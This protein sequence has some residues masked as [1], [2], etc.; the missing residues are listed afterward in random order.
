MVRF[1]RHL[2]IG[3]GIPGLY[4]ALQL[5]RKGENDF[6]LLE[7]RGVD[8]GKQVTQ[9]APDGTDIELGSSIEHTNQPKFFDLLNL[10][11]LEKAVWFTP[12]LTNYYVYGN[13]SSDQVKQIYKDCKK[14][15]KAASEKIENQFATL[16][17]LSQKVLSESEFKLFSTCYCCWYEINLENAKHF[18]ITEAN[19]GKYFRLKG[20]QQ[21]LIT[22]S[23]EKVGSH[24]KFYTEVV[25]VK[26]DGKH[27]FTTTADGET[28]ASEYL[29]LT[30]NLTGAKKIKFD[31]ID[32]I[33]KY[34]DLAWS[35][36]CMRWYMVLK[37]G[38]GINIPG[39][40]VG[41]IPGKWTIK[42]SDRVWLISYVDGPLVEEYSKN[43][44][45]SREWIFTMNSLFGTRIK[46]ED[47]EDEIVAV[48]KDA[49]TILK[50]E[51]YKYHKIIEDELPSKLVIT[52]V[53]TPEGQGWIE[54]NLRKI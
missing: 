49:Y 26:Y 24:I 52:T 38:K 18:F 46:A 27:Y 7:K 36:E 29:Y 16:E 53:T 8:R 50:P 39:Y 43:K 37:K 51:W 17:E 1:I 19:E 28:I 30:T 4:I 35:R 6:L 2:I 41:Q 44:N 22:L 32:A 42:N 5:Q 25:K 14:R 10:L 21:Q 11:D 33:D 54:G 47:V 3:A 48:W 12:K 15:V 9:I 23:D 31:G 13:L 40:I 34:L 45:L 20:G